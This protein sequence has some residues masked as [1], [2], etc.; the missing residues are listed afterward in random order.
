M[1]QVPE[2][3]KL[4]DH[5]SCEPN[6]R[7]DVNKM[8]RVF[9]NLIKNAFDAMPKKGTLKISSKRVGKNVEIALADNGVGMSEQTLSKLFN[10]LFTTK[11][12]GIGFGLAIC[13]RV[14]EAHCGEIRVESVLGRGTTFTVT[15]P[16]EQNG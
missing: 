2:Q 4:E 8:E 11:A 6:L 15:L 3:I 1:V 12:Q 5:T 9:L 10:P 16:I 14:V 7:V 13:K